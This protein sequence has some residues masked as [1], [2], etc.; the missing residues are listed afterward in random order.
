MMQQVQSAAVI[1]GITFDFSWMG[2]I[3]SAVLLIFVLLMDVEK[4]LPQ[5]QAALGKK[6]MAGSE[7]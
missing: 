5:I 3:L 2:V 4:Y 6:Q 1:N 7:E